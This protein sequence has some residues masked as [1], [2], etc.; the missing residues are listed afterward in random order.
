MSD[1][2]LDRLRLALAGRYTILRELGRGGMATVYLAQDLNHQRAVALKV[3]HSEFATAVRAERFIRE[4]EIAARLHHPHILSLYESGEAGGTLY[5]VMPNVEGE[6]L[7]ERL[8]REQRLLVADALKIAR[9]VAGALSYAHV[10]GI[11]HRDIKPENI[12]LSDRYAL[13]ADFGIARDVTAAGGNTLTETG[14]AIGTPVYMSPEQGGGSGKVD[15][16]SDIYSLGCVV[17]EML[18][19]QPPFTGPTAQVILARH[20]LDPV[21]PLST[22][23]PS[24]P[25]SVVAATERALAKVPADRFSTADEFARALET[26][27]DVAELKNSKSAAAGKRLFARS[28]VAMLVATVLVAVGV[29]FLAPLLSSS[30]EDSAANNRIIV[31]PFAY[32]GSA[33]HRDLGETMVNLLS[34]TLDGTDDMHTVDPRDVL[35]VAQNDNEANPDLGRAIAKRFDAGHFVVGEIVE[36]GGLL[37]INSRLYGRMEDGDAYVQGAVEGS[38]DSLHGLVDDLTA[39]LLVGSL[40]AGTRLSIVAAATTESLEALKAY[41]GG[42]RHYQSGV[43]GRGAAFDAFQRTVE[44][45]STFALAWYRLSQLAY[46]SNKAP[47]LHRPA[48]ETALR[49]AGELHERE[50]HLLAAYVAYLRGN[51]AVADSLHRETLRGYPED[52][53][54]WYGLLLTLGEYAHILGVD[55]ATAR[56]LAMR[57]LRYEPEYPMGLWHIWTLEAT[58]RV[59]VGIDQ[60]L[61]RIL[62]ERPPGWLERSVHAF[63]SGDPAEEKLILTEARSADPGDV[64]LAGWRVFLTAQKPSSALQFSRI[65]EQGPESLQWAA[66]NHLLSA[67]YELARG[68]RRAAQERFDELMLHNSAW[69]LEDAAYWSLAPAFEASRSEL[70]ARRDALL[71]WNAESVAPALASG[72]SLGPWWSFFSARHDGLHGHLRLYLLGRLSIELGETKAAL[73]YADDLEGFETPEFAGS[74]SLDLA[75]SIRAH[76]L[77]EAGQTADALLALEAAPRRV[78]WGQNQV[79][80]FSTQPQER[81]LRAELLEELG[82]YEDALGWY[83]SLTY[84]FHPIM[85]GPSY[86]RQARIYAR[87]GDREKA[88]EYYGRFINLWEGSDAEFQH[89]VET[90]RRSIE[91]LTRDR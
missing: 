66:L 86:L 21:P 68:Q 4:I 12:F 61:E 77:A 32:R 41:L 10:R 43:S 47:E 65:V 51:A 76:V 53:E 38:A 44:M 62:V 58:A 14:L 80:W 24:V 5:Y 75:Q 85:A 87:L 46:F 71:R 18:A 50:Q 91:A 26:T 84:W 81:Y 40:G 2:S 45:D 22:A 89:R 11:V 30:G 90:A 20:A 48:G 82:R 36:A 59:S 63:G 55:E 69:A 42:E 25:A 15:G 29:R 9:D 6:T 13:I 52:L 28:V 19:G 35:S 83:Q 64:L 78:P 88:V 17:Y 79:S 31:L 54:A 73:R 8:A 67:S 33:E 49:Y 7:R 16:R 3:L 37:R 72:S 56:Q 34:A 39:Q 74:L 1:S 27:A 70:E 57:V 60:M 23:R